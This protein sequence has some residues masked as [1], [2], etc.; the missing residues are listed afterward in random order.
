MAG[1]AQVLVPGRPSIP[2]SPPLRVRG[3]IMHIRLNLP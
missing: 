1:Q 3:S 2:L